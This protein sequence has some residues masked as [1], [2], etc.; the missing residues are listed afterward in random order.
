MTTS[1]DAVRI[2][3]NESFGTEINPDMWG[4]FFE[5]INSSADGGLYAELIRNR[6]FTFTERDA[7][8]W[9]P[10]TGWSATGAVQPSGS[11][12]HIELD[13]R[14]APASITNHGFGGIPVRQDQP[15]LLDIAVD[16]LEGTPAITVTIHDTD[17]NVLAKSVPGDLVLVPSG[18]CTA[19]RLTVS[20]TGGNAAVSWVSLFPQATWRG[21]ANGLRPDLADTIA[22]LRP[23]FIR[24]PGGCVAH[25]LGLDNVYRWKDTVGP[26]R[27][28]IGDSNLWGYHQSMGLG[29]LEYFRFCEQL[30]A[31]PLPVLAAGV[32]CQNTPGGQAAFDDEQLA[33]YIRDIRD[34]IEWANGPAD[35]PWGAV[36]AAAGHLEPF[37]LRYIGIGN[38]DEQTPAFRS[39]FAEILAVL[40]TEHPEIS[41]VGTVGPFPSGSDYEQGW[42]TARELKVPIVDE[43]SYKAPKWYFQNL[44]RFDEYDRSGPKVYV[45]EYGSRGNTMLCALAEAAYMAAMER[46]GD[47]VHL[48]SYAPLLAK[49]GNTQWE[50]D[51]VYFDNER[52]LPS[53]NYW[54]QQMHA[55]AAGDRAL[56]VDVAGAPQWTRRRS[57]RSRFSVRAASGMLTVEDVSIEDTS[58]RR[59]VPGASGVQRYQAPG[60]AHG[61]DVIYRARV[62]LDGGQDGFVVAF[63]DDESDL[64]YEWHFGTW[65]EKSLVLGYVADGLYDEWTE[66]LPFTWSRGHEF[67]LE[68]IVRDA[69]RHITC[70][71]DGDVVHDVHEE[72]SPEERFS[73]TAIRDAAS[74]RTVVKVVNA[75]AE[76]VDLLLAR[77]DGGDPRRMRVK[78]LTAPAEA[79]RPFEAAPSLPTE[80][81]ELG[82]R[83]R[84]AAYS[85][86]VIELDPE[87]TQ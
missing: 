54:V 19:A 39:R 20:V 18:D 53:L 21:E 48:A 87:P 36:R 25:G 14:D 24:F 55:R 85:F 30:G 38:E 58:G 1:D 9:G 65:Q 47:V 80:R 61:V 71:I 34:L 77:A 45:G 42:A 4:V 3:V 23:R 43:H 51:L 57:E 74:G 56:A 64:S 83:T 52:V 6:D 10:L 32:C 73:A 12:I 67:D 50:P 86:A 60:D 44:D 37:S 17:G 16:P 49:M 82:S 75:T 84:V 33:T 46:N 13:G 41:V 62:R 8:G 72:P 29:Y 59:P 28:R 5:D 15:L 63:G 76:P 2:T 22:D 79:G 11:P 69:G 66:P 26:V 35:S 81:I 31:D 68:V 40:R 70:S 7:P 27:D 78:E